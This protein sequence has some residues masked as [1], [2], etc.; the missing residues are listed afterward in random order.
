MEKMIDFVLGKQTNKQARLEISNLTLIRKFS[1]YRDWGCSSLD[2]GNC[3]ILKRSIIDDSFDFVIDIIP[4]V[5]L[6]IIF[7]VTCQQ[8]IEYVN[9]NDILI[10]TR[11]I[12][13]LKKLRDRPR[14]LEVPVTQP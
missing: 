7:V 14:E 6:V 5:L 4:Y 9:H 11:I 1:Y 10:A 13:C 3:E 8:V 2:S 12:N